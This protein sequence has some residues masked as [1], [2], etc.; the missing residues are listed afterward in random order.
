MA[1]KSVWTGLRPGR[2]QAVAHR[3]SGVWRNEGPLA[4]L[5]KWSLST[6]DAPAVLAHRGANAPRRLTYQEL[7]RYVDRFAGALRTLGVRAQD[8]V[9]AQLPGWWQ[10]SALLLACTEV[11]AVFVPVAMS[12]G[13]HDLERTLKQVDAD[14]CVTVGEWDGVDRA[15]LVADMHPRL[16]SLR[17]RVLAATGRVPDGAVD[18]HQHFEN[19]IWERKRG[20]SDAEDPDRVS[21]ALLTA[22]TTADRKVAVHT[23]NTLYAGAAALADGQELAAEDRFLTTRPLSDPLGLLYSVMIPLLV[24]GTAVLLETTDDPDPTLDA[25]TGGG[26]TVVVTDPGALA[27]L[28]DSGRDKGRNAISSLRLVLCGSAVVPSHLVISVPQLWGLPLRSCWALAEASVPAWIR[29]DA[30]LMRALHSDGQPGPGLELD[31][32]THTSERPIAESSAR[33]FVRGGGLCLAV[34]G[35]STL[36][37]MTSDLPDGWYDTGDLA[38]PDGQGGLRIMGRAEWAPV[39]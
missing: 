11:G 39:Q 8:V 33:L 29:H 18:F 21:V 20:T 5:R 16:P 25:I 7:N 14:V 10:A 26:T 4:D 13:A 17:H 30:D 6:P 38:V 12:V 24:G 31:F 15:G 23:S 1:K 19:T 9:V 3:A 35:D 37:I 32:R 2:D 27:A 36:P 34:L 22:G 28:V